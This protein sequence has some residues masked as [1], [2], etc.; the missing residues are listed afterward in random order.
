MKEQDRN[1]YS[2]QFDLN[3]L[4]K[5][6]QFKNSLRVFQNKSNESPWGS[7]SEYV[8]M[9]PYWTPYDQNGQVKQM[10]EDFYITNENS[11]YRYL[12]TNPVYDVSLHSVNR[13]QYFGVSNNFQ[14]RY[15]I[16]PAFYMETNFSL[17]KQNASRD[18]FYSA[19]DSRFTNVTD[20]A[21]RGSYTVR[22]ENSFNYESL[23]TA[24][25][26]LISGK[27]QFFSNLGFNFSSN[28]SN[29][30]R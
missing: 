1:N 5:K 21:Q 30:Y 11:R 15:T 18:Q 22:N 7:F 16:V 26:N 24:N 6:F 10:L 9:N 28:S 23:T 17:N 12:Q 25:L 3:Y 14:M 19:Q 13:S 2:G 29:Y 4:L 8:S 20:V 27:H